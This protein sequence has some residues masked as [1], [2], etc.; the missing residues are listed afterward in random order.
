[1]LFVVRYIREQFIVS[2]FNLFFDSFVVLFT[3]AMDSRRR[4]AFQLNEYSKRFDQPVV[5][6]LYNRL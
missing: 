2:L 1:M 5:Q 4:G 3:K 6:R